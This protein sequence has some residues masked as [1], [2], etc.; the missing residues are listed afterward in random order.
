MPA[1]GRG[2]YA[3]CIAA[4]G[5]APARAP[6][7]SGDKVLLPTRRDENVRQFPGLLGCPVL[8]VPAVPCRGQMVL[9]GQMGLIN[10]L[11]R[12]DSLGRLRTRT[13]AG[14]RRR[15]RLSCAVR[16]FSAVAPGRKAPVR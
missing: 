12:S 5:S 3:Q 15:R 10:E 8:R 14:A 11:F 9:S 1:R 7:Q 2:I 16:T 13:T 4:F 6:L